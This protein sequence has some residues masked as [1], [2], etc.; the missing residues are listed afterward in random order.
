LRLTIDGPYFHGLSHGEDNLII[1]AARSL[2][3]YCHVTPKAHIRLTK[4]L[5]LSS[6]I[7]GGSSDAAATLRGLSQLWSLSLS[8]EELEQLAIG[9]G[10]D[11]PVCLAMKAC[12]MQG[13]GEVIRPMSP[14][15]ESW[16]VLVNPKQTL[17]TPDVFKAR[18]G[19][20]SNSSKPDDCPSQFD[21]FVKFLQAHTN[22][23]TEPAI[24]IAPII[25]LILEAL[26][27]TDSCYLARMSG[28]GATCFGLYKTEV[29]AS[30]AVT[31]LSKKFPHWWCVKG[32]IRP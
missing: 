27:K 5:P 22:D 20:F 10:A 11:I 2:S 30:K 14:L 18:Q 32:K 17:S 23:L 19:A 4:N 8:Q 13:I 31:D 24:Q 1:A 9:L 7:G 28:S 3:R 26:S 21:H 12:H 6:G 25:T 15:P 16:L 29:E